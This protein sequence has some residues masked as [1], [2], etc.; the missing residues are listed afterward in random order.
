MRG[1]KFV[2]N[3]QIRQIKPS[4]THITCLRL[5]GEIVRGRDETRRQKHRNRSGI[6][7][8]ASGRA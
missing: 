3:K 1:T 4:N 7:F 5:H 2:Y 8:S 6:L